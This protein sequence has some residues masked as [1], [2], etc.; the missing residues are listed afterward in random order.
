MVPCDCKSSSRRIDAASGE[1]SHHNP[2]TSCALNRPRSIIA[3]IRNISG[4]FAIFAKVGVQRSIF[5]VLGNSEVTIRT[6]GLYSAH[7]NYSVS[8]H[9]SHSVCSVTSRDLERKNQNSDW[10]IAQ[11]PLRKLTQLC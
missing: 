5:V 7:N 9:Q 2:P 3:E 6:P 11:R 10:L 4:Y 1:S 8:R